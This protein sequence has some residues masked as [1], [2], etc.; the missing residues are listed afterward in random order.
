MGEQMMGSTLSAEFFPKNTEK[1]LVADQKNP[2][3]KLFGRRFY[4]DQTPLEYLA[5]FLL[6]FASPKGRE[7]GN[8]FRFLVPHDETPP[9]YWPQD[10]I[11][12]KLFAF[13]PTSKLETRHSIHLSAYVESV[14][15]IQ[16]SIFSSNP[17]DKAEGAKLLQSFFAGFAGVSKTRTWVT[18]TFL[19]VSEVFLAREITWNHPAAMRRNDILDWDSTL[20][21]F[22]RSTHNFFGRGGE[23]I[24]LQLANLFASSTDI[25]PNDPFYHHLHNIDL[26]SLQLSL[27]NGLLEV[28]S[29]SKGNVGSLT[30]FVEMALDKFSYG[31][32]EQQTNLGWVPTS[33]KD[34]AFL[35]AC[36]MNNICRAQVTSLEKL[37]MLEMLFVMHVLRSLCFQASRAD[38]PLELTKGFS[39]NYSWIPS[40]PFVIRA[41]NLKVIS[42]DSLASIESLLYRVLRL[43]FLADVGCIFSEKELKNGDDNCYR[44]FRKFSKDIGLVIPR[45]GG[46]QRFVLPPHILRL[47]VMALLAPGERV[48]LTEFYARVF[49][50]FGI[51]VGPRELRV[52]LQWLGE[53]KW[54]NNQSVSADTAWIEEALR[55]GGFLVEL[56]DAVSMVW[57]PGREEDSR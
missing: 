18:H 9:C 56:S 6:V 54:A 50:H 10:R 24:F 14:E 20:K 28:L 47:L 25:F 36:E 23:L 13:F 31:E 22:D 42:K 15:N 35:L 49:S 1:K 48:R 5:E 27:E 41:S 43:P 57:N 2:A 40:D 46:G 51:A 7:K 30:D 55:Q 19:P 16:S 29:S 39:G 17:L 32:N 38:E 21:F 11:A 3:I 44:L 52:A 34:E 33:T 53:G 37:N 26:E 4:K 12:L 8:T 45:R